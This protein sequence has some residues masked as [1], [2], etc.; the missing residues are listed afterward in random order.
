MPARGEV[1]E[2]DLPGAVADGEELPVR[3]EPNGKRG[4]CAGQRTDASSSRNVPDARSAVQA[5]RCEQLS[6]RAEVE[7]LG[8][9]M[10]RKLGCVPPCPEVVKRL[11]PVGVP[12]RHGVTVWAERNPLRAATDRQDPG[13]PSLRIPEN[14][15]PTSGR[16]EKPPVWAEREPVYLSAG[17]WSSGAIGVRLALCHS[18]TRFG[19]GETAKSVPS[20]LTADPADRTLSA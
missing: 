1:P 14:G 10:S 9:S 15:V 19:P 16:C 4:D 17:A 7:V 18:V 5:H 13:D 11:C 3:R 6:V 2:N 12:D 8:A 20:G